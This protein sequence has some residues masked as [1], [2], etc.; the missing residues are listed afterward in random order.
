ME[1]NEDGPTN[2][3][4]GVVEV[5]AE[6]T[7]DRE[8]AERV[9]GRAAA[10]QLAAADEMLSLEELSAAAAEAGIEQ[11]LV[12]QA[13]RE[14]APQ[15]ATTSQ[16][17]GVPT[18]VVRR[19]WLKTK[20]GRAGLE[21]T[22]ARLDAF[23]G[24]HGESSVTETAASWSARHIHV[25]LERSGEGTVVQVSERFVN[26]TNT[27]AVLGGSLGG[28]AGMALGAMLAK[29]LILGPMAVFAVLPMVA[30][31][32]MLGLW[33]ARRRVRRLVDNAGHDFDKALDSVEEAARMSAAALG[34][35]EES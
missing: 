7:F 34:P 18:R 33:S 32:A 4:P 12:Q 20:L 5:A 24:A 11:G 35:A 27:M 30:V 28:V 3:K 6:Q 15:L 19:R 22:V 16:R 1:A 29:A 9:L 13:A 14:L 26:T 25:T 8:Q 2:R 23:F 31:F 10:L 21:R 17:L